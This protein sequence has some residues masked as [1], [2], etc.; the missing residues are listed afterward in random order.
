M[1]Q[2]QVVLVILGAL[3]VL[4]VSVAIWVALRAR[5]RRRTTPAAATEGGPIAAADVEAFVAGVLPDPP[6]PARQPADAS[7]DGDGEEVVAPVTGNPIMRESGSGPTPPEWSARLVDPATWS[8]TIREESARL[9]RFGHPVTVVMAEVPHLDALADW[10][11][12]DMADRVARE[13]A[14]LLVAQGRKADR[15]ARFPGA[16]FGVLLVETEEK[17]AGG[18]V[19]R[20]RAAAD[21]WLESAGLST[22]LSVG[23]ASPADGADVMAAAAT[24]EQRM[25]DADRGPA[26]DGNPDG[27]GWP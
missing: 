10:F 21:G 5:R 19:K 14:R 26:L 7:A 12:R 9:A 17:A 8:Q 3:I 13:T 4:N 23:W 11:G 16:R 15:I 2:D 24:A 20:V 22:R 27:V 18:Y 6:A 25:R 1:T